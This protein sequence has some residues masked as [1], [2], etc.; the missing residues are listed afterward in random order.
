MN[1][2]ENVKINCSNVSEK[3]LEL[4]TILI[5]QNRLTQNQ[6][7]IEDP[8]SIQSSNMNF[9]LKLSLPTLNDFKEFNK[10]IEESGLTKTKLATLCLGSALVSPI[11]ALSS[12]FK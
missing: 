11:L 5:E 10:K 8:Q 6:T 4:V 7:D 2:F 1:L 12:F 9:N 3:V